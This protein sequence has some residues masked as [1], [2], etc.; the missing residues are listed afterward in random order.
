[1]TLLPAVLA[2]T[3]G[4]SS[5]GQAQVQYDMSRATCTDYSIMSPPAQR[6]FAAWMSGWYNGKA[7]RTEINLQVYQ[8]N[9]A[10]MQKWCTANPSAT[11]M[12][13]IETAFRNASSVPG[14]PASI[15]VSGITCGDFVA[16]PP[17]T[18]L[19]VSAWTA[20]YASAGKD[21][22]KIDVKAFAR[23]EK[24]VH[25]ACTKNKKQLLLP[26]VGKSWQ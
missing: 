15:D 23:H 17:E 6:D 13:L 8:A 25:A 3:L 22:A 24:A 19:I 20:G 21:A 5:P 7:G 1:M 9:L 18:Q 2:C 11:V 26:T 16:S 10:T 14:G 4:L 12:S